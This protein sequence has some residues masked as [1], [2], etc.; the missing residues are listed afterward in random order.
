MKFELDP[1]NRNAPDDDLLNDLKR[2]A[3]E[4]HSSSLSVEKYQ[5]QGRFSPSTIARR[6]GSWTKALKLA[7]LQINK[8]QTISTG[9]LINDLKRVA[10]ILN[11]STLTMDDYESLGM[12]SR[13]PFK[14]AF[15]YWHNALEKAGLKR[16]IYHGITN[17]EYFENLE[18]VWTKLGRQPHRE[19]THK[20]LSRYSG[21]AYAKRFGTWRKAL[22]AFIEY[23]KLEEKSPSIVEENTNAQQITPLNTKDRISGHKTNRNIN[24]RLRFIV[25]RRDHFK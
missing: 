20:P 11:K 7:G 24:W 19:D 4:M 1:Y 17:E 10:K 9:D 6:F 5:K 16:I 25:M 3:G 8:N 15:R 13:G 23:V 14:K 2:V 12:H 22:E 21:A 18:E